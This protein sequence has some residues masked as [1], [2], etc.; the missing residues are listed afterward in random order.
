MQQEVIRL[1]GGDNGQ[2]NCYMNLKQR[3]MK[4][5]QYKPRYVRK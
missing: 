5:K 4:F 1:S 3:N 2:A